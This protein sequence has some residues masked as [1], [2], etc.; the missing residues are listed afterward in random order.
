[1]QSDSI[2][3]DLLALFAG[4]VEDQVATLNRA[5]LLLEK[6]PDINARAELLRTIFRSAHSLK[7]AAGAV[8]QPSIE[9]AAH[10]MEDLIAKAQQHSEAPLTPEF[11][12]Q[13]FAGADAVQQAGARLRAGKEEAGV[14]QDLE[15]LHARMSEAA[16]SF[17]LAEPRAAEAPPADP[18]SAAGNAE[19]VRLPAARLDGLT[20][21]G[22]ELALARQTFEPTLALL[23]EFREELARYERESRAGGRAFRQHA[24]A[25]SYES[26]TPGLGAARP[27]EDGG[28]PL[29]RLQ[30][31]LERLCQQLHDDHRRLQQAVIP[32]EQELQQVRMLPFYESCAGLDRVIRDLTSGIGKKAKLIIEGGDIELDRAVI[33][34]LKPALLH[35]VRNAVSHGIESPKQRIAA[36][37]TVDGVI[38]VAASLRGH[39]VEITV[40]D[41]GAGIALSAIRKLARQKGLELPEDDREVARMIF[42]PGFSTSPTVTPVAGRGVGL[43]SV[44]SDVSDLHGAVDFSF[45]PGCGTTFR[46][47]VPLTLM[48]LRAVTVVAAGSVF[49]VASSAVERL[50]KIDADG[51]TWVE[52]SGMVMAAGAPA[53]LV[54]LSELLGLPRSNVD[55]GQPPLVVI[56]N[57]EGLR[58]ALQVDECLAE[59]EL[60]IRSL[61]ARVAGM[62]FLSGATVLGDGRVAVVLNPSDLARAA[63]DSPAYRVFSPREAEPPAR[64]RLLLAEDSLTTRTLETTILEAAGYDVIAAVDGADA[65]SLL[66]EHG[67]DL[68]VTDLEMPRMDGL[69]LTEA[70]RASTRFRDTPV[71][72]LTSVGGDRDK[73]RGLEAGASAYLLKSAFD[74]SRLLQAIEEL[75]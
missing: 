49:A 9:S 4:E 72:L 6:Q 32:L 8:N 39:L 47:T 59:T 35:L 26:G 43:D 62:R 3:P 70:I 40:S 31:T 45:E 17:P 20:R 55:E 37:K 21:L 2:T 60:A 52:G 29:R 57:A 28:P 15:R 7:G 38:R 30:E 63:G 36:G 33:E 1:M 71:I 12:A 51:I 22:G 68:V 64:K 23:D 18:Q 19:F 73:A 42:V 46:I 27:T 66:Q 58:V 44:A 48:T 67:A 34:R 25:G 13:L 5:L 24:G 10:E 61:G 41:D 56:I 11:F 14:R 65:W 16:P 74:Q 54:S 69:A 53:L 50:A 75:L